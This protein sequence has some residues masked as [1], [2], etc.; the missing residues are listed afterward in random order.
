[1]A[2]LLIVEENSH[3][4]DTI[5][6]MLRFAMHEADMVGD[7]DT[8]LAYLKNGILPDVIIANTLMPGLDGFSLSRKVKLTPEWAAIPVILIA[9]TDTHWAEVEN[10]AMRAGAAALLC[11]PLERTTLLGEVDR[12]LLMGTVQDNPLARQNPAE[13]NAFLRDHSRWLAQVAYAA[14]QQQAQLATERDLREARLYAIDNITTALGENL[15]L[16]ETCQKLVNKTADLMRAQAVALYIQQNEGFY[17]GYAGGFGIPTPS[18]VTYYR[19][20]DATHPLQETRQALLFNGEQIAEMIQ[21]FDLSIPPTSAIVSPLVARGELSAFLLTLRMNADEPFD[22][23][24]AATLFSLA[25]A[26]GLALRSA[27]LFNQ[28]ETAYEDLQELDRRKSEFVAI[29]SHELRTPIAIMLGY[30]N[31]LYDL[32]EDPH[33]R[34]QLATIEKQANFLTGMVDALLNLHELSEE[35]SDP[36]KVR[37]QPLRVDVLLREALQVTQI[38]NVYNKEVEFLIDC[39]PIEIKGDDL[40]LMLALNNLFDNAIKFSEAGTQVKVVAVERPEGGVVITVEDEGIGIAEEHFAAI[41]E[42]FYQ[43]EDAITRHHG[44]L[45]LGLAIVRGMVELHGGTVALKSRLGVGSRFMITLLAAPPPE[46]C[47]QFGF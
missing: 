35:G 46:R 29:T 2:R 7:G 16:L 26:A 28:L 36:I 21:E 18:F 20:G 40:R 39:D 3:H 41:F 19:L 30:A 23:N 37:C 10:L 31:L 38:H 12:A 15:N 4:A 6:L 8:A 9:E 17:L 1:M 42:P 5:L 13:E 33:K 34:S 11:R 25:G 43:V 47:R 22:V 24:D 44:G 45:G 27:L 14:I 32:E